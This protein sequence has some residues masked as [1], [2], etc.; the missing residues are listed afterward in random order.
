MLGQR[1][2]PGGKVNSIVH[3]PET[4]TVVA[5][6]QDKDI[7]R[8]LVLELTLQGHAAIL[9]RLMKQQAQASPSNTTFSDKLHDWEG[10]SA[11]PIVAEAAVCLMRSSSHISSR[12]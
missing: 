9:E 7:H 6:L 3:N 10:K 12:Y 5:M 8:P 1:V 4:S 11:P 2:S